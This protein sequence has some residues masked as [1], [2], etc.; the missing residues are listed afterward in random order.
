M[1][2]WLTDEKKYINVSFWSILKAHITANIVVAS[3]LY[4]I[5]TILI[6]IMEL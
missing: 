2:I 3:I 1:Q 4:C 5:F 6:N